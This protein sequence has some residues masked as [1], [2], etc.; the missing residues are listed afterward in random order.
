VLAKNM[1]N[2]GWCYYKMG[3]WAKS[4]ELSTKA[5]EL[6]K[7]LGLRKDELRWLNNIGAVHH[8]QRDFDAAQDYYLRAVAISKELD[9]KLDWFFGVNNL[10]EIAIEKGQFD[11]AERYNLEALALQQFCQERTSKLHFPYNQAEIAEGRR[12]FQQ[13]K[14]LFEEVI[15]GAAGDFSL[16]WMAQAKLARIYAALHRPALADQQF[17]EALATYDQARSLLSL[18]E[19]K[20]T[21]LSSAIHFFD[22]YVAFLVQQGKMNEALHTVELNRARTLAEGLE[23]KQVETLSTSRSFQPQEQASRAHAVVLAYWLAPERSYLWAITPS[24]TAIFVLPGESTIN[25]AVETYRGVL[26][27]PRDPQG[28]ADASG[29]KLYQLL[30]APAQKLIPR[31]SH[32]AIIPAGSLYELN[33]ETLLVPG[34]KLHY[35]IEDVV[36]TN[37]SSLLLL[38][39]ERSEKREVEERKMLLIGDPVSPGYPSLAHAAEEISDVRK[40]F[41][42]EQI[43]V[44]TSR[45]ATARAYLD[46]DPERFS[47]IHFVAH[48]T[49]SR[50]SPLDSAVILSGDESSYKLYARD[51]VAGKRLRAKL[52]TISSCE[53]AGGQTYAG[54]GLVGLSWAFLRAGAHQVIAASWDVN[55]ASTARF[56]SKFYEQLNTGED[57]AVALRTAKLSMLHSD[58]I[59][60]RPFYWAPF[61]LY[62]GL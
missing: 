24:Q 13:A 50:E 17:R 53:G 27:G 59:Y 43:Q 38:R 46:G 8:E 15:R 48:G 26:A 29:Q 9:D 31:G 47:I 30:V 25:Q 16:R 10:A 12:Q 20:L 57:A 2:M 42:E 41:P 5:N 23:L 3:D 40:Y 37:A 32:V 61:Q 19:Y 18:E 44:Y 62:N 56:M 36:I 6:S 28:I 21:F 55:D 4:L 33:F 45:D 52:V 14:G 49:A 11:D 39:G 54:E 34:A 7:Q 51:I 35:W 1:G 60:Q 22:D 58:S